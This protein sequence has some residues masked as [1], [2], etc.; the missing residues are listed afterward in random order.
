MQYVSPATHVSS[1]SASKVHPV[2]IYLKA[3]NTNSYTLT[4]ALPLISAFLIS[5]VQLNYLITNMFK[6]Y[7]R[8]SKAP[9]KFF[10]L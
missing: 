7:I 4:S 10:T 6:Y 1:S 8:N 2:A 9:S 3:F 5:K